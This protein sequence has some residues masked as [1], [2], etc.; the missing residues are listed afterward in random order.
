MERSLSEVFGYDV[1]GKT[2]TSQYYENKN[3][4]MNTFI[5]FFTASRKD[6]FY[7]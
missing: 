2:G 6:T 4:N 7:S 5:S 3:K 1:S